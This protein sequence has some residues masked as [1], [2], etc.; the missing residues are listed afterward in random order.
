M[1]DLDFNPIKYVE[2]PEFKV[3]VDWDACLAHIVDKSVTDV[4]FNAQR[5]SMYLR[6]QRDVIPYEGWTAA[7][8]EEYR[9]TVLSLLNTPRQLSD[10]NGPDGSVD[11]A[12]VIGGRRFRVNVYQCGMGINAALRPL[13]FE[14]F[15]MEKLGISQQIVQ[16]VTNTKSGLILVTGPTGSGKSVTISALIDH[17]HQNYS[18]NIITIEDPVEF[19]YSTGKGLMAQREVGGQVIAFDRALRSAMR[20]NPDIIVVGE[21]RD[22]ETLRAAMQASETG[23]LV[24]ATLHTTR[25]FTTISRVVEMAPA[26][27]RG[28]MRSVLA[29][30]LQMVMCQR[31]MKRQGGGIIAC[32]EI[33]LQTVAGSNAIRSEK[34]K[35]LTNI[36]LTNR[37]KGMIDWESALNGLVKSGMV[38]KTEAERYRTE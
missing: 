7:S 33:L 17:L 13:P 1:A 8:P 2:N 28:Q 19:I 34:E 14:V 32:R 27:E 23:H 26:N 11:F 6:I 16:F 29:N 30:N 25:V 31:L 36:A 15:P 10:L 21:I 20:Q 38:H 9:D 37:D 12:T 5:Q 18:Y 22:L 4:L 24:F 3:L 35:E